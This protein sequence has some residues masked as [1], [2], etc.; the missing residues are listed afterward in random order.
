MELV[1]TQLMTR[2]VHALHLQEAFVT[3]AGFVS[4]HVHVL[5]SEKLSKLKRGRHV[6]F[7]Y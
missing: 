7:C 5:L 3:T 1:K 2:I 4:L 6:T